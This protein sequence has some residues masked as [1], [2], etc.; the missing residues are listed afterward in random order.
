ME[1]HGYLEMHNIA[2]P[3][4]ETSMASINEPILR[5]TIT[6]MLNGKPQ[7]V[8]VDDIKEQLYGHLYPRLGLRYGG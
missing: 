6:I 2:A 5:E 8:Y 7:I 1:A 3:S 4:L